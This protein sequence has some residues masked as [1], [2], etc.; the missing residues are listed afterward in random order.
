M[1]LRSNKGY[2]RGEIILVDR[3]DQFDISDRTDYIDTQISS[4]GNFSDKQ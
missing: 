1:R 2:I 4:D 3:H